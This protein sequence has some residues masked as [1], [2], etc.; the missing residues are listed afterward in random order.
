[1]EPRGS[2]REP[3]PLT[4][5]GDGFPIY[6][7]CLTNSVL[8]TFIS[9]DASTLSLRGG[10]FYGAFDRAFDGAFER[11]ST[12]PSRRRLRVFEEKSKGFDKAFYR[13]FYKAFEEKA[14][15]LLQTQ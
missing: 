11:P 5:L 2:P 12:R 6:R 8:L 1:M 3:P 15:G 9:R 13:A 4:Y 7:S 14:G 10:A